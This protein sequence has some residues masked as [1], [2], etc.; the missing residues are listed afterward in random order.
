MENFFFNRDI[1]WLSFNGR[2]LEEAARQ[3]VPLLERVAFLSIWS[4]N[5]D[6][7]FR[8]RMPVLKA[9]H[10][11]HR[12]AGEND[13]K[14][15]AGLLQQ[16][17][18]II[19]GQQQQFGRILTGEILPA[20]Q[21]LDVKLVYN[22][23]IPAAI[24]ENVRKYFLSQVLAF[25]KPVEING[26]PGGFFPE[27]NN[28]Y[29]FLTLSGEGGSK[30]VVLNIPS[31]ELPRFYSERA[32]DGTL[33]IV[34]LD[35]VI[36]ANVPLLFKGY[37][38]T[39][40]ASFKITRD[41]ELDLADEYSGDLLDQISKQISKRK[42]GL[43]TRFLYSP[44]MP[45]AAIGL[46]G[47]SFNLKS[48]QFME[49][50]P[51]HNLKDL[52]D[53]PYKN[54]ALKY[55]KWPP[56]LKTEISDE[57]PLFCQAERR[58]LLFHPPYHSYDSILR[59]F[60]EA[61]T[62]PDV[63]EIY[64]TVYRVASNSRIISALM[65]AAANGKRVTVLVELKARFDEEN[66]IKWARRMKDAGVKL[67]YS[68]TALKVHAKIAL[69]KRK[70]GLRMKYTGLLATGNFNESTASVYTDHVL[71]TAHPG[72]MREMELLF[73]FLARRERPLQHDLIGFRHLLVA[74]FNL[75]KR[76][77]ELIDREIEFA[78]RG[79]EASVTIKLNNLEERVLIDKLYE[80]SQ[81]GVKVE[82]IVRSICC[83][84][85]GVEGMSG[86]IRVIRIVDRFLEHGR[87]FIFNNGGNSEVFMGSADWMNRNIYRRIEVCFP[88]Y[89]EALKEQ[90][91]KMIA[92][93]LKDNTQAV[94]IGPVEMNEPVSGPGQPVRSQ[95]AIYR[96]LQDV[97]T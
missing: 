56:L 97:R 9:L 95:E 39:G 89:D 83:L 61:A 82:L 21:K 11:I 22:E 51:Y 16:A 91:R 50:G 81:A 15:T 49:G 54:P 26:T 28:L 19:T 31:A 13:H 34:F 17:D 52:K 58:D 65:T 18:E 4:S 94:T 5:L 42:W 37:E 66:N 75:Q 12:P 24:E 25:L 55:E 77:L 59:F 53:L 84:A 3:H 29:L 41:A 40:S 27:N 57:E 78:R 70:H 6:E 93:Q 60:N 72:M 63:S 33:Y 14:D 10:K 48:A 71:M 30:N 8:V 86:N 64:T 20:L 68:V 69:V 73:V 79:E 38:V 74:Q 46:A 1:S 92:I 87:V 23:P 88:V 45:A 90:I 62:D 2:V 85:P 67:I 76:F 96:L 44:G 47:N 35:D 32:G 36:R 80:A 7:F 43:A